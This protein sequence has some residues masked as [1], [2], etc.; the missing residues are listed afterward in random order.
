[1]ESTQALVQGVSVCRRSEARRRGG[2]S[3]LG[4]REELHVPEKHTQK[5]EPITY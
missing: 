4:S 5:L 3:V 1:M 2:A